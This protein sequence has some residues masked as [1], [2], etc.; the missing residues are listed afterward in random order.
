MR[1]NRASPACSSRY[2]TGE[3]DI[4]PPP[5]APCSPSRPPLPPPNPHLALA[6][7]MTVTPWPCTASPNTAEARAVAP[8]LSARCPA[9]PGPVATR[10]ASS[11]ASAS[12]TVIVLLVGPAE[13]RT[14]HCARRTQI[15]HWLSASEGA[16][17]RR[18]G[19]LVSDACK[20]HQ[21][22]SGLEPLTK[23]IYGRPRFPLRLPGV[24]SLRA[25]VDRPLPG[26]R[27]M[28]HAGRGQAPGRRWRP[29]LRLGE[30]GRGGGSAARAAARGPGADGRSPADRHRRARPGPRRRARA[31]FGGVARRVA[32]DRQVHADRDGA[33]ESCGPRREGALRLGRGVGRAGQAAGGAAGRR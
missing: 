7:G 20:P 18:A 14:C 1:R 33:R 12:V 16:R 30:T 6:T 11:L 15:A 32:G 29:S 21:P 26:L 25:Y 31:R 17:W 3:T 24:R 13:G 27:R 28:E 10:S 2:P 5:P 8:I 23:D 19:C 9:N 4:P 22:V